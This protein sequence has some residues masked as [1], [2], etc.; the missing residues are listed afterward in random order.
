MGSC[1]ALT[2]PQD[3]RDVLV[4]RHSSRIV[5]VNVKHRYHKLSPRAVYGPCVYST[6]RSLSSDDSSL[7]VWENAWDS[8][9]YQAGEH[10][11]PK[12]D[13]INIEA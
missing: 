9:K 10:P 4:E 2:R 3:L 1:P 13:D 5:T 7:D 8:A 6:V 11:C 12:F